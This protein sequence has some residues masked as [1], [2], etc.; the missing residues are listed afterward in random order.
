M[1]QANI[2]DIT[3]KFFKPLKS[4]KHIQGRIDARIF[5]NK[6]RQRITYL[7]RIA[8]DEQSSRLFLVASSMVRRLRSRDPCY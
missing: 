7:D 5:L 3:S 1:L 4:V 8:I 6:F 2:N